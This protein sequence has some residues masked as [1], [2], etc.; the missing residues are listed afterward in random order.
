MRGGKLG[1]EETFGVGFYYRK[2][3]LLTYYNKFPSF[4]RFWPH[5]IY[6]VYGKKRDFFSAKRGRRPTQLGGGRK[7]FIGAKLFPSDSV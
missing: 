5:I 1:E 6:K 4:Y 7:H 2:N 3:F